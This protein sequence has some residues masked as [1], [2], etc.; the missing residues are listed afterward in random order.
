MNG[1][2]PA[3][4]REEFR[5]VLPVRRVRDVAGFLRMKDQHVGL[6]ELGLGRERVGARR[7]RPAGVQQ[8]HPVLEEARVIVRARPV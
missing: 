1:H 5:E 6:V 4:A 8:R 7:P 2:Q 3:A